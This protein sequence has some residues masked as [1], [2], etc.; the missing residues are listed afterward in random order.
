MNITQFR[1]ILEQAYLDVHRVR[2]IVHATGKSLIVNNWI[3][4]GYSPETGWWFAL[5]PP[6]RLLVAY[7]CLGGEDQPTGFMEP[8]PVLIEVL[9]ADGHFLAHQAV[10]AIARARGFD[11]GERHHCAQAGIAQVY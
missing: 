5:R 9:R 10:D 6:D 7:P 11:G 2:P 8:W 4:C 1:H 3:H